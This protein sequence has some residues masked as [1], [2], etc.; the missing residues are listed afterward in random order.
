MPEEAP[1]PGE[2]DD[3]VWP[4]IRLLVEGAS[5]ESIALFLADAVE[6][7]GLDRPPAPIPVAV[8]LKDWWDAKH[9]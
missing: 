1:A 2:Y 9:G 3:I 8:S 7:Y 6:E 5:V 4:V